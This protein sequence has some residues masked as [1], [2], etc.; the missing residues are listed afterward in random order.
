[1]SRIKTDAAPKSVVGGTDTT[2][3][4]GVSRIEKMHDVS[5]GTGAI[6]DNSVLKWDATTQQWKPDTTF[7]ASKAFVDSQIDALTT[8]LSHGVSVLSIKNDPPATAQAGNYFIVGTAPTGVWVGHANSVA[9][10]TVHLVPGEADAFRWQ[11]EAPRVGETHLVEDQKANYSWNGTSWVKVAAAASTGPMTERMYHYKG[12]ANIGIDRSGLFPI[13]KDFRRIEIRA[14]IEQQ[15]QQAHIG[16]KFQHGAAV[17]NHAW[18]DGNAHVSWAGRVSAA[19][20]DAGIF[21]TSFINFTWNSGYSEWAMSGT[22]HHYGNLKLDIQRMYDNIIVVECGFQ[23]RSYDSSIVT[24]Q[25]TGVLAAS[26]YA[27]DFDGLRIGSHGGASTSFQG[28]TLID[29]RMTT[30][31]D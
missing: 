10:W 16:L 6:K 5:V 2:L 12:A 13:D 28:R 3:R 19:G 18:V 17:I 21:G 29:G 8:G 4:L 25:T 7:Y 23:Y 15:D 9:H 31:K 22:V 26:A 1:M 11:F 20:K 14:I 27:A 30:Y 24:T